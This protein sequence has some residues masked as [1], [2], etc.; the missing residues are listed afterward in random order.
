MK[1]TVVG[2]IGA[3]NI[4]R[5]HIRGYLECEDVELKAICDINMERAKEKAEKNRI[6]DVYSDY[7]EL[8]QDKEI[9]AVSVCTWNDSHASISIDALKAG[10]NVLCEKPMAISS[11]QAVEM[12]EASRKYNKLLMIGFVRRFGN[13]CE[14]LQDFIKAGDL[15]EIYYAKACYLR[16]HGN[17]GG[18]FSDKS[19]SG[20]GPLIDLGV[21]VIDLV[22]YLAGSPKPVS[23]Y[24]VTNDMLGSREYIKTSKPYES[25]DHKNDELCDVEDMASA[26]VRFENGM[27]LNLETSFS[28]NLEKDK[29]EIELFGTKAGAKMD[30]E[31]RIFTDKNGYLTDIVPAQKTA[32]SMEGLFEKEVRHFV[33][34][35]KGEAICISKA[36]D[37][38]EVMKIIDAVYESA[39]TKSEVRI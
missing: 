1:K 32:L 20:G 19:R 34:C 31:I 15:G 26:M 13:D 35:V 36:E 27:V 22:R 10:K 38:I 11:A 21:H 5:A 24:G 12:E 18:W 14:V 4:S 3:G 25:A 8:L 39:R 30:P 9:D 23:V 16:R 33:N 2:I 17:P 29:G 6:P 28:L 37:G 7:R